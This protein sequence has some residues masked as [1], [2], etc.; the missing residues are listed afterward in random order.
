MRQ[1]KDRFDAAQQLVPPLLR[2][3]ND[4][5]AVIIAI[6]R[7][8]L[9]LGSVLSKE[10]NV[11]LD[12]IFTKKIPH[13]TNS[14]Y[15]IGAAS[16]EHM[17][18]DEPFRHVPGIN[19]YVQGQLERIRAMIKQRNASYRAHMPPLNLAGKTVIVVDDGI[20]TGNTMLATLA[21]IKQ[22]HPKKIIVALPV[23]PADSLERV[24]MQADEV[25]CLMIPAHFRAVSQFYQ[26]FPQVEDATAITLLQEA[27]K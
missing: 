8:A 5:N 17:Q 19:E 9:E 7:G 22:Q 1:F 27:N 18:L 16:A 24:K 15:A 2:Y 11:P 4:P 21:F 23:A 14:E 26:H 13:P 6:P 3:K 12:V 25:I 20:A 10:L